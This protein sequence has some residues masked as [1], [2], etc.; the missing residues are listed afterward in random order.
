VPPHSIDQTCSHI[1]Q[2]G[3][4]SEDWGAFPV[5][6][7]VRHTALE[8]IFDAREELDSTTSVGVD[9]RLLD[10]ILALF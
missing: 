6:P 5:S 8:P 10:G 7:R 9:T 1:R 3:E 4:S 2:T